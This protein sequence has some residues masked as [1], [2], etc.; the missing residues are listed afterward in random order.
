[1]EHTPNVLADP[2]PAVVVTAYKESAVEYH[3]RF[4]TD[5]AHFWDAYSQGTPSDFAARY[6][7]R[8]LAIGREVQVLSPMGAKTAFALDVDDDCHL[9][10]RYQDGST[11]QLASGEI[12]LQL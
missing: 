1:M 6:R 9:L 8:N 12:S 11:A 3:V 7:R 10:V 2:A 5:I 4:W